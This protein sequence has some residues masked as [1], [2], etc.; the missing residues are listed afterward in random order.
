MCTLP[1]S[2]TVTSSLPTFW[3]EQVQIAIKPS[4]S[5]S[6]FPRGTKTLGLKFIC[7]FE[8][9]IISSQVLPHSP[10]SIATWVS[11]SHAVMIWN[12]L[13]TFSFTSF[14]SLFLGITPR[15]LPITSA[16]RSSRWRLIQF[17][18]WWQDCQTSSAFFWT[19]LMQWVLKANLL[20][21]PICATSSVIFVYAKNMK[22]MTFLTGAR[23]QS[24]K[25][26]RLSAITWG[27][28]GSQEIWYWHC[29]LQQ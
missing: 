12:P 15:L 18:A 14:V 17:P 8:Q 7:Q 21:I 16:T 20:T 29:W 1:T 6:V 3:L 24:I 5:I 28:M 10:R 13:P 22:M 27:S 2:F 9:T 26:M 11:N 4:S 23:Q 19:T 25:M